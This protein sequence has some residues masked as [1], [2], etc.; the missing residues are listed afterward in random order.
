MFCFAYYLARLNKSSVLG[1]NHTE[2]L[3]EVAFDYHRVVFKYIVANDNGYC[4]AGGYEINF[5]QK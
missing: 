2:S 3:C 5:R 4:R 1:S